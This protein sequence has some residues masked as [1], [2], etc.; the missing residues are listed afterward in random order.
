MAALAHL[1]VGLAAKRVN[2]KVPLYILIIVAWAADIIWGLFFFLGVEAY[3]SPGSTATSP[4]SHGLLMNLLWSTT[5]F[6]IAKF[7]SRSTRISIFIGL[8]FFSHWIIDFLSHPMRAVMPDDPMLPLLFNGSPSVGLGL[9][10]TQT[11]VNVGEYG[12]LIIGIIFYILAL[13]NLKQEKQKENSFI[14]Q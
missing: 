11:G 2:N 13:K 4:W 5:A 12:T 8:L 6:V 7:I 3:P 10:S 9:Y 1:G 14:S